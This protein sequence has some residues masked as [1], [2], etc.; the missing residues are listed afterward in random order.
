M[1]VSTVYL[2]TAA[3]AA[4]KIVG[5]SPSAFILFTA[6]Q[7][8]QKDTRRGHRRR[9]GFTAAQAAQK[10]NA[11]LAAEVER[12]HCRTGSSETAVRL[13]TRFCCVR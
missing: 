8:A 7:A 10:E 2:F 9:V 12:V 1:G 6:A 11:A 3:Q 4:Q 13:T 5:S